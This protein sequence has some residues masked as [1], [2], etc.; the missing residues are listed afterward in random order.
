MPCKGPDSLRLVF[1][2]IDLGARGPGY[3]LRDIRAGADLP[4]LK[5]DIIARLAPDVLVLSGLDYDHGLVTLR[6]FGTMIAQRGPALPHAF[7]FPSNAGL[8]MGRDMNGDGRDDGPDD[9]QG[10]GHFSGQRALAVLSRY[11]V[12]SQSAR[13]FSDFLWQDL[14]DALLPALDPAVLQVQR[15]SSTGHWDIPIQIS[16]SQRLHLLIYQAGPPVFGGQSRRNLYRNHDETAFWLALLEGRLPMSPPDGPFVLIGGSNL[17]PY[18]GDGLHGVMRALLQSP[19]LQDPQP[20]SAGALQA[21][22]D[23]FSA[24]HLGPHELDTVHWPR[25]PGNLRVSYIL[26]EAGIDVLSSGVL[27]PAADGDDAELAAA[28]AAQGISHRPVWL[29]IDL[30]S[31]APDSQ[32]N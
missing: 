23:D 17:D 28:L 18:D 12:G 5:G 13:D 21:A 7:A 1:W 30:R 26:P 25:A 4:A 8:R 19:L 24:A 15:L 11:P 9:T 2:R 14:P 22:Q 31:I 10:Y 27:W 29:D 3:A 16:P 20:Q 6:A 32:L